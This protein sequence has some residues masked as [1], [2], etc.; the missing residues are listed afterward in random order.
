M[1]TSSFLPLN[2]NDE[3][4]AI[5]FGSGECARWSISSSERP[6]EKY[7]WSFFSL[8]ST[9]GRTAIDF[10]GDWA[11]AGR[12]GLNGGRCR[13]TRLYVT[14][15]QYELIKRKVAA[16]E[17]AAAAI[18][19]TCRLM[20]P[21]G[22]SEYPSS[23]SQPAATEP[24]GRRRNRQVHESPGEA[25]ATCALQTRWRYSSGSRVHCT[26]RN[27]SGT[28]ASTSSVSSITTGTRKGLPSAMSWVR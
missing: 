14:F 16:R 7:S 6:S 12:N 8:M 18:S 1:R 28:S 24:G 3:V 19:Y 26:A 22:G 23:G 27:E 17:K 20:S 4:R 11:G 10:S 15:R 5:T 9:N 13:G 2:W 21:R 25:G